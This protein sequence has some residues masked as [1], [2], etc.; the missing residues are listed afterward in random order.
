M[1]FLPSLRGRERL[2]TCRAFLRVLSALCPAGASLMRYELDEFVQ[3][4]PT[5]ISALPPRFVLAAYRAM[6]R[7]VGT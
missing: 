1:L 2:E 4:V 7:L 3:L 5:K 6:P